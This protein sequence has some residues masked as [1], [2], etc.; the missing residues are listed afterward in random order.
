MDIYKRPIKTDP[1]KSFLLNTRARTTKKIQSVIVTSF[2]EFTFGTRD[3]SAAP[4]HELTKKQLLEF[5]ES[6]IEHL[7]FN[8]VN[9]YLGI[10]QGF[11]KECAQCGVIDLLTYHQIRDV[12]KYKGTAPDTGRALNLKEINKVKRHFSKAKAPRDLRNYAIFALALGSGLRRAEISSLNIES[13]KN[14]QLHIVGK[15]N[16][17]RVVYLGDFAYLAVKAW[18]SQLPRKRG[19]LFV[20]VFG[21]SIKEDRLKIKGIHYVIGEIQ[22]ACNL[23]ELTTHDLRRTFATSLLY[24]NNDVFVVQDLLGHSD[25]M[26]TKRYDKRGDKRKVKAI[27]TLPF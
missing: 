25:P 7:K 3:I 8:T 5:T 22:A 10:L 17:A 12:K 9:N 1:T 20:H 16:K 11:A 24:A 14:R 2:C 6:K 23:K 19:A 4:W 18:R 21:E 15:G 26:T 27:K 13:I